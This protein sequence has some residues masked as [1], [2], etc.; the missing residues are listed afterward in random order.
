LI[1]LVFVEEIAMRLNRPNALILP[2]KLRFQAAIFFVEV[3]HARPN[4]KQ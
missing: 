4:V 1:R 2:G 3:K